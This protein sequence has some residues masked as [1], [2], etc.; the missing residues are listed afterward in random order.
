[1]TCCNKD[2]HIKLFGQIYV[3]CDTLQ[4]AMPLG[5]TNMQWR[6]KNGGT[7]QHMCSGEKWDYR[8]NGDRCGRGCSGQGDI[9]LP[10]RADRVLHSSLELLQ[11]LTQTHAQ[12]HDRPG[13][14]QQNHVQDGEWLILWFGPPQKTP[15]VQAVPRGHVRICDLCYSQGTFWCLW[16]LQPPQALLMPKVLVDA[17]GLCCSQGSC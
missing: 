11:A 4:F 7:E 12:L 16:S 6:R 2:L 15:V 9:S 5:Q 3:L 10:S 13:S 17:Y 14:E 8:H 1:M